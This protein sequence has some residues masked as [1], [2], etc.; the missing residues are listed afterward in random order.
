M[1]DMMV[2]L[3]GFNVFAMIATLRFICKLQPSIMV[4]LAVNY[5]IHISPLLLMTPP[6]L[7]CLSAFVGIGEEFLLS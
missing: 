2:L 6:N 7:P 5:E 4:L 1:A 3:S